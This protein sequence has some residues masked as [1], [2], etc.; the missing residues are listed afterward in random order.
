MGG[1]G[2]QEFWGWPPFVPAAVS[3]GLARPGASVAQIIYLEFVTNKPLSLPSVHHLFFMNSYPPVAALSP[4]SAQAPVN[5]RRHRA[6]R[7]FAAGVAGFL[8]SAPPTLQAEVWDGPNTG[9][10]AVWNIPTNWNPDTVPDAIGAAAIFDDPTANRTVTLGEDITIGSLTF[11]NATSF[12]NRIGTASAAQGTPILTF[13]A[14]GA[15]PA[16]IVM[17]GN[18]T[19]G[20][21]PNG[22]NGPVV[23]EDN[24]VIT[25][26]VTANTS[27]A[28]AFTFIGT[29][30]AITG[31]GGITKE[32]PGTMTFADTAKAFAGPLIINEGRLRFNANARASGTSAV[33]IASGGQIALDGSATYTFGSP[34][35]TVI[36]L[37]GIG[38]AAFPGAIRVETNRVVTVPNPI[39]LQSDSALN[40]VGTAG[41]LTL[42]NTVSGPGALTVGFLP[43]DPTA[44]GTLV[45]NA[46]NSYAGG[47]DVT[48]GSLIVGGS[49]T[50]SLG[51]GDVEVDSSAIKLTIETGVLDAIENTSVLSLAGGGTAGSADNGYADLGAGVNEVVGGLFLGGVLQGVGTYGSSLSAATFKNDEYFGGTGIVTVI[52]EPGVAT[53]VLGAFSGFI[54]LR[55]FRRRI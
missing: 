49:A 40:I 53:I 17:T 48:L 42:S 21:T 35:T 4:A 27:V 45:L 44:S 41:S 22:I 3:G 12:F 16:T 38:L 7:W 1:V 23:L 32:G 15:G 39:V 26:P 51:A 34:T 19:G 28:G 11:N 8:A 43:G 29:G 50:A 24:L 10:S 46:D 2:S 47:T 54:G 9:T 30:S 5:Q 18:A 52:P 14:A 20:T 36:T 6:A 31:P 55:R 25:V 33:T 13:D 37:N